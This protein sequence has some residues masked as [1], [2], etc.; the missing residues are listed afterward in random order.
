MLME[1]VAQVGGVLPLP[2]RVMWFGLQVCMGWKITRVSV[3][4]GLTVF[5]H[6]QPVQL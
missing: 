5:H 1:K 3:Q 6:Q 2:A 4:S